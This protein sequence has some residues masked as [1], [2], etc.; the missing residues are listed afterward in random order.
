M[1]SMSQFQ[2]GG[3]TYPGQGSRAVLIP[4]GFPL[5]PIERTEPGLLRTLADA[6]DR[7][8]GL[9]PIMSGSGGNKSGNFLAVTGDIEFLALLDP[10]E[11]LAEPVFRLEGADPGHVVS[12]LKLA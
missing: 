4:V 8:M 3:V 5:I 12:G 11:Q 6:L 10:I 9:R 2:V 7:R 1:L